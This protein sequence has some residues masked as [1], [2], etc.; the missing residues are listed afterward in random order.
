MTKEI[1][2]TSSSFV[3]ENEAG[4]DNC[5]LAPDDPMYQF[6]KTGN[7]ADINKPPQVPLTQQAEEHNRKLALAKEQGI[8]P[9]SPAWH[10]L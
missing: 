10:L 2:F 3:P 6:I 1:R 5:V 9:G 4:D 7:P 8:K